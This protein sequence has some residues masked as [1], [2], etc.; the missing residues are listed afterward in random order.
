MAEQLD[1]EA[2]A[3]EAARDAGEAEPDASDPGEGAEPGESGRPQPAGRREQQM[4]DTAARQALL[5]LTSPQGAKALRT[6]AESDGPAKAIATMV[7]RVTAAVAK[8]A[9]AAGVTIHEDA[10]EAAERASV[11]VLAGLMVK[12]GMAD[13]AQALAQ[14]A[15]QLMSAEPAGQDETEETADG[16]AG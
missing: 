8:A 3:N 9:E 14:Q 15:D 1:E 7:E 16:L 11:R 12:A 4:F 6:L 5:M 10:A 13:D 2:L